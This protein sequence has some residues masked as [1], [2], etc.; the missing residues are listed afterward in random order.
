MIG[1]D[2]EGIAGDLKGFAEESR[3]P[4]GLEISWIRSKTLKTSEL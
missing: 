3:A 4:G 2:A 1:G